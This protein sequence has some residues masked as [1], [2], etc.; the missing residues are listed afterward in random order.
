MF[1]LFVFAYTL[2]KIDKITAKTTIRLWHELHVAQNIAHDFSNLLAPVGEHDIY[3]AIINL[4]EIRGIAKCEECNCIFEI[5][6]IAHPPDDFFAVSKLFSMIENVNLEKISNQKRWY[7]EAL[8]SSNSSNFE[9][10]F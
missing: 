6:Q 9:D 4:D 8:Y 2:Y 7:Y 3:V 10:S 1:H 5:T